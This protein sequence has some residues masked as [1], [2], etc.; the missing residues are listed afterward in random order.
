MKTV[1][2]G[3]LTRNALV[4]D[5]S[6]WKARDYFDTYYSEVV[7][8]D[9]QA[10]LAYQ[11]DVLRAAGA[12]FGR[13]LEYGCGPTLHRAIA[14]SKYT[15]RMDMAD[16]LADNLTEAREWLCADESAPEWNRF[17]RYV[18][19]C[20]GEPQ[21]NVA[22]VLQREALTRQVVRG[23]YVSDAR[24]RQPLGPTRENFYDLIITGFCIDAIS[25]DR[26]VWTNCMRNVTS[27]LSPGGTFIIH[28]L[29]RCEAYKCGDR[30]FPGS[31]LSIDDMRTAMSNNGFVDSS[32]DVQVIPCVENEGYG[33]SGILTAS[34]RK[35]PL[36]RKGS[37]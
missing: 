14:A 26:T 16:W 25:S 27:M 28:A 23:L 5:Y 33:Y 15:F 24:L 32:I 21:A 1:I 17:T 3:N 10:V 12:R 20:E 19:A 2:D 36:R 13:G 7:L 35:A 9:E 34:G 8:P 22:Q 18:L 6:E 30:M 11:I 37:N 31:N 29:H 4:A